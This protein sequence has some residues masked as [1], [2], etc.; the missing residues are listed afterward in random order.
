MK[1][2]LNVSSE[3]RYP[4]YNWEIEMLFHPF[5]SVKVCLKIMILYNILVHIASLI[6]LLDNTLEDDN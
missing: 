5:S 6:P 4:Q 3:T 1:P 2:N